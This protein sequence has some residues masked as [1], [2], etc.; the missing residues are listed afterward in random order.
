MPKT[1][2]SLVINLLEL[3]LKHTFRNKLP[4]NKFQMITFIWQYRTTL[5]MTITKLVHLPSIE[6]HLLSDQFILITNWLNFH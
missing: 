5:S 2:A 3:Y 6:I 1:M 4:I